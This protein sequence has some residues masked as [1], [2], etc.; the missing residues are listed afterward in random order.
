MWGLLGSPELG[1]SS[2]LQAENL[3]VFINTIVATKF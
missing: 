3:N 2:L 1:S